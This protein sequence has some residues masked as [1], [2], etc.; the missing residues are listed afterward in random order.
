MKIRDILA[1]AIVLTSTLV[2]LEANAASDRNYYV[3]DS[4]VKE[5]FDVYND[6]RNTFIE[7]IPG[8]VVRGA[9][10]D[11]RQYIV[12]GVPNTIAAQLNGREIT[13]RRG[14]PPKVEVPTALIARAQAQL[15]G[16]ASRADRDGVAA[17]RVA[18][19]SEKAA[20]EVPADPAM[21]VRQWS[22]K[23]SHLSLQAL[24]EDWASKVGY[25]VIFKTRDFPLNIR[26]EK[27]ISTG[28]FWAALMLL[29]EA[30]RTSDAPFQIQPTVFKQIVI[31]PMNA[32]APT[33]TQTNFE[34]QK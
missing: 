18:D 25:E 10:V 1:A 22:M 3:V 31:Q 26:A 16:G 13:L 7:A 8:L 24:I 30:Y 6:G 11:G 33:Q 4:T 15:K 27:V 21:A 2:S 23:P 17:I 5:R 29:G 19:E 32:P 9:T 20:P 14:T 28:D 34:V 12:Y